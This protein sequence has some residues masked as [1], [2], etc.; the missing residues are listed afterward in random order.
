[1]RVLSTGWRVSGNGSGPRAEIPSEIWSD[2][3]SDNYPDIS[4]S[5]TQKYS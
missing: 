3:D 2:T 4:V 5:I 1:M